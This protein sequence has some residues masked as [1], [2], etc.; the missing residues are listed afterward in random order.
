VFTRNGL[1]GDI[2]FE[3]DGETRQGRTG[4]SVA[5][6]ILACGKTVFRENIVS[7]SPRGPFCMMGACFECMVEVDGI[8]NRQACLMTLSSGMN[9]RRMVVTR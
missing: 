4:D 5:S 3:L 9:I 2:I 1:G 7:K 6:A 8:P